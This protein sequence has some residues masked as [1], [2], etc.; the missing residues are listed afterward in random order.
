MKLLLLLTF[1]IA[2]FGATIIDASGTIIVYDVDPSGA[3][4]KR[5]LAISV[6]T[7]NMFYCNPMTGLWAPV[8][9]VGCG[10][11]GTGTVTNSGT[12]DTNRLIV[13]NGGVQVKVGNLGGDGAT[14]NNL[15]FLF[16][17]VNSNVGTFGDSTHTGQFTVNAKGLIT[18]AANVAITGGGGL[19]DPGSNGIISRTA[20][21]TTIARTITGT[22]NDI[23]VT[24]GS[25]VSGNPT[26]ALINT[27]CTPGTYGDATHTVQ[28]TLDAK[29]RC[30]A[31]TS[32]AISVG[33]T[34]TV[35]SVTLLGTTNQIT[36]TGTCT[37]TT[38]ITCTLS[39]PTN[40]TLNGD[41]SVTQ[42]LKLTDTTHSFG[43]L[44]G[45]KTSGG[46]MLAVLDNAGA[47]ITLLIPP[48]G[49]AIGKVLALSGIVTCP[50]L[51]S[52][53]PTTCWQMIWQ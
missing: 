4:P 8:S 53:S 28:V 29:G 5:R 45:G 51:L 32:V 16:N 20:L 39:I 19:V 31:A 18:A 36:A 49:E 2:A 9:C 33:G 14:S 30:T 24:N 12:L 25:G 35:T 48:S 34:G 10:T 50:D 43:M 40:P 13:G 26:L 41:V 44:M 37:G 11:A 7:G 15:N 52:G 6:D 47:P 23:S 21:N 42:S 3:C 27:A 22:A 46:K 1:S 17:T 38:I